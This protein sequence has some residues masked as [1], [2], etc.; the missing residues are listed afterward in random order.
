[1]SEEKLEIRAP[2][3]TTA[4][5]AIKKKFLFFYVQYNL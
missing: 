5:I 1:M 2:H 3:T 4:T